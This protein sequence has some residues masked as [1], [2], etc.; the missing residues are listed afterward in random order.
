MTDAHL[1]TQPMGVL[2]DGKPRPS[3]M[4]HQWA[5]H[6][7]LQ[8]HAEACMGHTLLGVQPNRSEKRSLNHP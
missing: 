3:R 6:A 1:F 8:Q 5:A 2:Q 4:G 7:P